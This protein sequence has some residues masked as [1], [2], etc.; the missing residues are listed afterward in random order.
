MIVLPPARIKSKPLLSRGGITSSLL[1]RGFN[2]AA[3]HDIA[4][5]KPCF[6]LHSHL[7]FSWALTLSIA[8]SPIEVRNFP[9]SISLSAGRLNFSDGTIGL[10][11]HDKAR[12]AA[13][14]DYNTHGRRAEGIPMTFVSWCKYVIALD[15]GSPPTT[16]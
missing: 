13:F 7:H 8:G 6:S 14:R 16:C 15:V 2:I 11:Q 10:V 3:E 4:S 1:F 9:V 5:K 12:V